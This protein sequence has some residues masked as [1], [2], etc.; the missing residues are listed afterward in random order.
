MVAGHMSENTLFSSAKNCRRPFE[1]LS[2]PCRQTPAVFLISVLHIDWVFRSKLDRG[3]CF[4]KIV[5]F[6]NPIVFSRDVTAA[7]LVSLNKGMATMLVSPTNPLG[8]EL[9]YHANVFFCF[10]GK[11]RLLIT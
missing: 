9:Y 1:D 8:I 4:S 3:L 2:V 11:T 5:Y 10:G 7:P 6:R